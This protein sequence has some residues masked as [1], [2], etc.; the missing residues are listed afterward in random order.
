MKEVFRST[1]K[2]DLNGDN[3]PLLLPVGD[4]LDGPIKF[5]K[6]ELEKFRGKELPE[7]IRAYW[8]DIMFKNTYEDDNPT[9]PWDRTL[10]GVDG[11]PRPVNLVIP[12]KINAAIKTKISTAER[13]VTMM[14]K[15][16]KTELGKF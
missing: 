16:V 8:L 4:P 5:D 9:I 7:P 6:T 12:E 10:G 11:T 15:M 3:T 14:E 1:F 13:L 2:K